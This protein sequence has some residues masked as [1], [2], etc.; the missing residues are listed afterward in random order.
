MRRTTTRR[1]RTRA[2]RRIRRG[3]RAGLATAAVAAVAAGIGLAALP[4]SATTT[5]LPVRVVGGNHQVTAGWSKLP[6]ATGY[7]VR[8]STSSS[9]SNAR[10]AS[11]TGLSKAFTGLTN[12]HKYYVRVTPQGLVQGAS[13]STVKA[14]T[15]TSAMPLAVSGIAL[16]PVSAGKLRVS[17]SGGGN[18]TKV[19]LIAGSTSM[20]DV[21][22][23]ASGWHAA[24]TRSITLTVPD[25]LKPALGGGSGNYIFVKVAQSNST[26][27]NPTR[28]LHYDYAS[29]YVLSRSS[30]GPR[31]WG[32]AGNAATGTSGPTATISVGSWNVQGLSASA[33]FTKV[34]QWAQRLP[35]VVA[36]IE[37]SHPDLLGAQE[38]GTA[39]IVSTCTNSSLA[40]AGAAPHCTEQYETLKSKLASAGT[41]YSMARSDAWKWVYSQP[42][43]AYV[44]SMLFYNPAKLSVVRSGF[45]SPRTTLHVT[46]WPSTTDQAGMWAVLKVDATGQRFL[47]ASIHLPVATGSSWN[48][49]RQDESA[50]LAAFLDKQAVDTDGSTMPI[51]L[52]GDL[53]GNGATDSHAGSLVL[54][55]KGYFDTG[56]T[57]N[58]TGQRYSSSNG[59]NGTDGPD[60]GYPVTAVIHPYATSRIDYIFTKGSPYTSSYAN[61]VRL[62]PGTSTFDTRYNGS[63]HNLQYAVLG[64]T[65]PRPAGYPF[66]G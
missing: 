1:A 12:G 9:M 56:S 30:N 2:D 66:T 25:S 33:G 19:A 31:T 4:A 11:T 62:V 27:S 40:I 8:L 53:N 15:A 10:V 5:P 55:A 3:L 24:T 22:H 34:D 45:V 51:V 64:L 17:W 49:I 36:N 26:A 65:A 60:P 16:T 41:R 61:L 46:N 28:Y 50:K 6:G 7:T 13:T 32:L 37:L 43:H 63:D 35:R 44:D 20:T 21:D 59:T 29:K 38:L 18:A 47:A 42:A 39:R 48:A 14:A 52:V 23:F 54:R 58:R 57:A